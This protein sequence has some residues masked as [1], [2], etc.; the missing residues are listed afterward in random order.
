MQQRKTVVAVGVLAALAAL[1]GG[2]SWYSG[3][4]AEQAWQ[5]AVAELGTV[6][7]PDAI[8]AQEYRRGV[9]SSQARLVL[10]WTPP[11]SDRDD[12]DGAGTQA[13]PAPRPLRLVVDSDVRHGPLPGARLAAAAVD[14]RFA[15]EG[16]DE[17]MRQALAQAE[18][19][20][21]ATVHHFDGSSDLHLRLPA[22]TIADD[23][24]VLRWQEL[25]Y[26]GTLDSGGRRISARVAWPE[27]TLEGLQ[28]DSAHAEEGLDDEDEEDDGS[29]PGAPA[30]RV[31][32]VL[33]GMEGSAEIEMID[34]LWGLGPGTAQMR[35]ASVQTR[36]LPAG[37][38]PAQALLDLSGVDVQMQMTADA[39][40]LGVDTRARAAGSIGPMQFDSIALHEQYERLDIEALRS[41]LQ[42][43]WRGMSAAD[44]Q[45]GELDAGQRQALLEAAPR[46]VAARP[47][48][49][50]QMEATVAGQTGRVAYG[51]QVKN[52][53]PAEQLAGG[54]WLPALLSGGALHASVQ[55]PRA[56]VGPLLQA[57]G[58]GEAG[59]DE[60]QALLQ[61]AQ[62]MGYV[63]VQDGQ[64][65]SSLRLE[66]GHW[67][68]NGRPFAAPLGA[69]GR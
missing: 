19:P 34:G 12:Q 61:Q 58:Q 47:A 32:V 66:G 50:M 6:V 45:P 5:R 65:S 68:L 2:A 67:T 35:A 53:P 39:G 52:A 57:T 59:E 17:P 40:T 22:G 69:F 29:A 11:A 13:T 8:A 43:L 44:A 9:F 36:R 15:L 23:G 37:N 30:E 25:V 21:L 62:G 55:M 56:W 48:Y 1:Y 63:Q 64:V 27:W 26:D 4:Q 42:G 41:V 18:G 46:L 51:V 38:A 54:A 3:R 33:R 16:M 24:A 20:R 60:V 31:T 49:Q 7:G 28:R 14:T 10:Q